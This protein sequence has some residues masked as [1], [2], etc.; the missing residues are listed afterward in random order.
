MDDTRCP[1]SGDFAGAGKGLFGVYYGWFVVAAGAVEKVA[2]VTM[3][4]LVPANQA[5]TGEFH[6]CHEGLN[7]RTKV[8]RIDSSGN[9][10]VSRTQS[11]SGICARG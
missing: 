6:I 5:D 1:R 10:S 3:T 9:V 4:G 7:P 11:G 2:S 8:V